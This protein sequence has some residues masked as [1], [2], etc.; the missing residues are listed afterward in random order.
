MPLVAK[1]PGRLVAE[2]MRLA[3]FRAASSLVASRAFG[4]D[5]FHGEAR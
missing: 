5:D 4:I 2:R 1:Y 3:D